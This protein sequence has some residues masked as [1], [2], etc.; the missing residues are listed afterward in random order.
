MTPSPA[1]L[2]ARTHAPACA[3]VQDRA[4]TAIRVL[5]LTEPLPGFPAH[6]DYVLV[7]A[8]TTGVLSWLQAVAP[9]GPRL[10]VARADAWFPD[11]APVLP[12]AARVELGLAG[13]I[14]PH[15]HCVLTVPDGDVSAA[16]ANLRAPLVV[17]PG[18]GRARQVLLSDASHPV[19]RPVRR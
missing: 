18:T 1:V 19:R 15:V 9:D 2:A 8:D 5:A 16:T 7:P 17:H 14:A 13:S 4:A 6:R 12:A 10:L 11:Y 3:P